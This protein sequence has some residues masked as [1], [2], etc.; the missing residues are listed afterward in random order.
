MIKRRLV[1]QIIKDAWWRVIVPEMR[2]I[3]H[4]RWL[5]ATKN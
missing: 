1:C 2:P 5:W 4:N 3:E